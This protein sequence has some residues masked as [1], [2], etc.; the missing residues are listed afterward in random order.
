M[1]YSIKSLRRVTAMFSSVLLLASSP[2]LQIA[3]AAGAQSPP[4]T[5]PAAAAPCVPSARRYCPPVLTPTATPTQSGGDSV[6][7]IIAGVG[8]AVVIGA[9]IFGHHSGNHGD[10][11]K[12]PDSHYL[13]T[14]GPQIAETYP[15]G[16]FSVRGFTRDN[17]PIV[18]DFLPRRSTR[19][20]LEVIIDDH[21]ISTLI[22]DSN[23]LAGRHLEK[24]STPAIGWAKKPKAATY[25]VRSVYLDRSGNIRGPAP[26]EVYGIGGG[27]RAVGS[28]A[29]EQL[30]F[31]GGPG[32][33]VQF[34]YQAKSP[35]NHVRAEVVRFNSDDQAIHIARV[36]EESAEDVAVG[37]HTG[38]W[39]GLDTA[40][41]TPS[42]GVHR[43]QVRAWFTSDDKS[44]VGAVAPSL[45]TIN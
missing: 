36:M 40:L 23:G 25:L 39:D 6:I 18:I 3:D 13:E 31:N 14:N 19:T 5:A 8:T 41:G 2:A 26:L 29:I 4:S 42:H 10:G 20:T 12:L 32:Q 27:P 1:L 28:V 15:V 17:W 35:F 21:K 43:F 24:L 30:D 34:A 22:I 16:S 11:A 7:P 44:W 37:R 9:L 33:P 45:L 38:S